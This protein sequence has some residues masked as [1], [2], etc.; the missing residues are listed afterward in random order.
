[1]FDK[2]ILQKLFYFS[3]KKT[4]DPYEAEELVQETAIEML[5]MLNNGYQPD[6]F[7]A[8]IWTV[9]RKRY[10]R[11]YKKKKSKLSR[12]E[13]EDVS[14][15]AE[16]ASDDFV[17]DNI[18]YNED[19]ELLRRELALLTKDY[20]EIVVS[21][22]IESRKIEEIST[23]IGLP[24]GTVKRKL[25]E[26]RQN[27]KEGMKMV[28]TKGQR[29]YAPDEIYI[30]YTVN[31]SPDPYPYGL[32]WNLMK[33]LS[34]KNIALELYNNPLT[35]EEL[36][37]SLGIALPYIEDELTVLLEN[38]VIIKCPDGRLETNF[39]I[40]NAETQQRIMEITEETGKSISPLICGTI[41]KNME[42]IKN[43]GFIN[44]DM[45]S[46]YLNWCLLHLSF[47][48][49]RDK[50]RKNENI[51]TLPTKR[52]SGGMWDILAYE[53]WDQP[54]EYAASTN[55]TGDNELQ[56][57][58]HTINVSDLY[59]RDSDYFMSPNELKLFADIIKTKRVK[60]SLNESEINIVENLIKNHV[61]YI[62]GDEIKMKMPVF[63]ESGKNELSAYHEIVSEI[64]NG[65]AY[66][67]IE[68]AYNY[69][70]DTISNSVPKRFKESDIIKK[71][72]AELV[73][74]LC[75]IM[76]YAYKNDIVKIPGGEDKSEITMYMKF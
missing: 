14:E 75:V 64:Y 35:L 66:R 13:P 49:L 20:R 8:W 65:E 17:E 56:F 2:E 42:R 41:E 76:R 9:I 55:G 15:Y 74:L 11:W 10:A 60:S 6:N 70:F 33:Q 47:N 27:I 43:I 1:M 5:R 28:R 18:L 39:I 34:S 71:A 38:D 58:H 22:Y 46:E 68:T 67:I 26:A 62:S 73:S 4:G 25:Y 21:Y 59:V 19:I 24:E 51:D 37:L 50:L 45:P 3:L 54:I 69:I 12:F 72:A 48:K 52:H 32:P 40:F 7:T 29:S 44:N 57:C 63:N 61:V 30:S 23:I 36:S 53:K 31:N 16:I